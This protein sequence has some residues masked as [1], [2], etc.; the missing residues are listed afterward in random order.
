MVEHTQTA[1]EEKNTKEKIG[2]INV[3]IPDAQTQGAT[4][5]VVI[6]QGRTKSKDIPKEKEQESIQTLVN[7]PTSSTPTKV[8]QK[9]STIAIP[10][11]LSTL[12]SSSTKVAK[13]I[14][15]GD[16][17]LD[18]EIVTPQFDYANMTLEDIG[19]MQESLEK[20]KQ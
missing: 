9:L 13:V 3:S 7:L 8:L 14:H 5:L 20:K 12:G 10:L 11:Q 15:Y 19:I 4:Q 2:Q 6:D 16:V 17:F 1:Q 18:E